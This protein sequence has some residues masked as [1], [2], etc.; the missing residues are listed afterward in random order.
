MECT[1]DIPPHPHDNDN[2]PLMSDWMT[3]ADCMQMIRREK[4]RL[5]RQLAAD[6]RLRSNPDFRHD[7]EVTVMME[8]WGNYQFYGLP[9][10]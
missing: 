9:E 3:P 5:L 6:F 1:T 8:Q 2:T 7:W 10:R 4:E